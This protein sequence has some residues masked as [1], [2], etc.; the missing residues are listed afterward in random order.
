MAGPSLLPH[1][2]KDRK[3]GSPRG[4]EAEAGEMG[5]MKF[6]KWKYK[7]WK[8]KASR[9]E[10]VHAPGQS[11]GADW[12]E[13]SFAAKIPGVLEDTKFTRNQKPCDTGRN[14]GKHCSELQQISS[15]S[16]QQLNIN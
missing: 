6:K 1:G 2:G 9:E 10:Q 15:S 5:F 4:W 11:V 7:K 8:Y 13:S 3:V 14:N 16:F 12:V